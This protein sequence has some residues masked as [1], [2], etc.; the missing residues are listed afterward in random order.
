MSAMEA[1]GLNDED[2]EFEDILW[3]TADLALSEPGDWGPDMLMTAARGMD[4]L[5]PEIFMSWHFWLEAQGVGSMAELFMDLVEE[6]RKAIE[7]RVPAGEAAGACIGAADSAKSSC[8]EDLSGDGLA[9]GG[10]AESDT[11]AV[12]TQLLG[13]R[14]EDAETAADWLA[15]AA[16]V[17]LAKER[18]DAMGFSGSE[19]GKTPDKT[20][21]VEGRKKSFGSLPPM[22]ERRTTL[23]AQS[24]C[25]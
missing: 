1:R 20:G 19:P 8:Y 10:C 12:E 17:G 25:R 13:D 5:W 11:G 7:N 24:I 9:G 3:M 16:A 14:A 22:S 23:Y 18:G 4:R 2:Q 21:C 6:G 15:G